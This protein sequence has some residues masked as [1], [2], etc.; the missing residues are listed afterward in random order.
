MP[1]LIGKKQD[2]IKVVS[3]E[4]EAATARSKDLALRVSCARDMIFF[5]TKIHYINEIAKN[6]RY[7][8]PDVTIDRGKARGTTTF[9]IP[10]LCFVPTELSVI[11]SDDPEK[12]GLLLQVFRQIEPEKIT[13]R[14]KLFSVLLL[15][16]RG[17]DGGNEVL[18]V[19]PADSH[20]YSTYLLP[21]W[22]I[23]RDTQWVVS[24]R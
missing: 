23:P 22:S 16:E 24:R 9:F 4:E 3:P 2:E 10:L 20:H 7:H 18:V 13:L 21:R 11:I 17:T 6:Q 1:S 12:H 19:C 5:E 15:N 8:N 14:D